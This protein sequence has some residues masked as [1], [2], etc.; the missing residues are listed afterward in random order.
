SD[1][2]NCALGLK[3]GD[4]SQMINNFWTQGFPANSLSDPNNPLLYSIDRNIRTPRMQQWHL[5]I[6][7]QLPA[8][9]VLEMSYAGS[10][11]SRL[12]GFYNGN[13]A[14]PST[15]PNAPLAPRRPFP[16]VDGTIDAF[17]SNT[18][19]N[20]NAVQPRAGRR[21]QRQ[22]GFFE[23]WRFSRSAQSR[24]GVRELRRRCSSSFRDQ[25]CL[26]ASLQQRQSIWRE[27]QRLP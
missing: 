5:G 27:C 14:T 10:H 23:Q 2:G 21:F 20:Y 26:R 24:P 11:G 13:Q 3:P 7:Y 15:D 25:L 22:P 12:Y 8:Q 17:R 18:I 6:E 4:A 1:P 19:S 9:T 16:A